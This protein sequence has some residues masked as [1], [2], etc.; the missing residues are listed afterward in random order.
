MYFKIISLIIASLLL[1]SCTKDKESIQ[2]IYGTITESV[3]ASG[4]IQSESQY[5][6]YSKVNGVI[7]AIYVKK[8]DEIKA[9]Q[10]LFKINNPTVEKNT[11]NARLAAANASKAAQQAKYDELKENVQMTYK[12]MVA[13]SLLFV[14]QS[15]LWKQS[16]GSKV[17]YEQRELMYQQS[18]S[19]YNAARFRLN[20]FSRQVQF[21]EKQSLNNVAIS[22]SIEA[23]YTL[24]SMTQGRVY[25]VLKE[26]GEWVTTATPLAIIGDAK[27]FLIEL[28]VDEKDIVKIKLGQ[29]IVLKMD[30]YKDSTFYAKVVSVDP[31]M[32]V[33]TRT[34]IIQAVFDQQPQLLYP[35]LTVEANIIIHSKPKALII[36]SSYVFNNN[37]VT[38]EDGSVVTIKTGLK[39]LKYIEVLE[40]LTPASKIVLP[41]V[42]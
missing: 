19:N 13:D 40:G 39:D 17:D 20:D 28:S 15:N 18:Q 27:S 23:D 3:Y 8:G 6:F 41:T 26:K 35:F 11:D 32:N 21:N 24:K 38:L 7:E 14:R 25:D 9:Q 2:P 30:S 12:K 36:P 37:Q 10:V 1:F 29:S 42:Q 33:R 34:F 22:K 4:E 31:I 16:I 5:Q